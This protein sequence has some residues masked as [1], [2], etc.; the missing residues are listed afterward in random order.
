MRKEVD[1]ISTNELEK[2]ILIKGASE[3]D[4]QR[5]EEKK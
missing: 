5:S 2:E 4:G 3:I 1:L